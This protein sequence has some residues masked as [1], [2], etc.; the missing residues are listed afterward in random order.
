MAPKRNLNYVYLDTD[1]GRKHPYE[2]KGC[3]GC[4]EVSLIAARGKYC[5]RACS[6]R[7]QHSE[8]RSRQVSGSEHYA[9]KGDKAKYQALHNRVMRA[10]GRADSC[11]LRAE[12]GCES[13]KYEWAHVHGTDPGDPA[14]YR[15]LCKSCHVGYD[16]QRGSGHSSSKLSD[17]QVAEI[18]DAYSAGVISQQKLANRF[19]V[20]QK[21]I[22]LV[23]TNKTYRTSNL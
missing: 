19:G 5:S 6:A 22:H 18:R 21:V 11:E 16:N 7:K 10:R 1:P 13:T 17:A 3:E 2:L 12:M 9:W 20:S 23:V 4:G 8:G 14:N 15:K